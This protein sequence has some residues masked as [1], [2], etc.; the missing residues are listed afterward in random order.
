MNILKK[1]LLGLC[2]G[3]MLCLS[4]VSASA[5]TDYSYTP[6]TQQTEAPTPAPTAQSA[7]DY[8]KEIGNDIIQNNQ[9]N[10]IVLLGLCGAL[11]VV[12]LKNKTLFTKR[13]K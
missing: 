9:V 11:F 12:A 6:K 7:A 5:A 8:Y 4:S 13:R 2:L 10:A 1:T 3:G